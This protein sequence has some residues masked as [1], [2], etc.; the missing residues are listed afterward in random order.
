M[1][2]NRKLTWIGASVLAAG[3]VGAGGAAVAGTDAVPSM[4]GVLGSVTGDDDAPIVGEALD[5][6]VAAATAH[7]GEGKVTE[8][9]TETE[10]EADGDGGAYEVE[11]L[12]A[13]G[14]QVEVNLDSAFNVIGSE[15]DDDADEKGGVEDTDD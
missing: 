15:A 1:F 12:K 5:K 3:L 11:I 8:T 9:E 10:T 13:S 2:M 4:S 6:A 7:V 14:E